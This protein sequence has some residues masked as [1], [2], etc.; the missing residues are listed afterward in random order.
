MDHQRRPSNRQKNLQIRCQARKTGL[1]IQNRNHR[2]LCNKFI[3][4]QLID[5]KSIICT[6]ETKHPKVKKALG[7]SPAEN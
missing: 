7:E 4:N 2:K 5:L 1:L 3:R 6:N